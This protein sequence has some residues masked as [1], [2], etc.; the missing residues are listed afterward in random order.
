MPRIV[1]GREQLG[2]IFI[3]L[4]EFHPVYK[5]KMGALNARTAHRRRPLCRI[6][7]HIRVN[8]I[9]AR[10]AHDRRTVT[11]ATTRFK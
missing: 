3:G 4:L 5:A 6:D 10:H 7:W 2:P 9:M 11:P 8:R 1:L